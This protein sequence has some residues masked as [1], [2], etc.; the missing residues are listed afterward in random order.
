MCHCGAA[1]CCR[2]SEHDSHVTVD[3]RRNQ[4]SPPVGG[5][6]THYDTVLADVDVGAD[7]GCVHH[8]VLLDEDV[9]PDVEREERHT[10]ERRRSRRRNQHESIGC[11]IASRILTVF[12]LKPVCLT[13]HL[14]F[15][16]I[17][18]WAHIL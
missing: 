12:E 14:G 5:V 4:P 10:L 17:V 7:L 11:S 3:L 1:V 8:T 6:P 18:I 15:K 16:T 2:C 9:V 13:N